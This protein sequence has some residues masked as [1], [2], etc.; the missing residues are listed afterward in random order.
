MATKRYPS[1]I[2]ATCVLPW[3]SD[4]VVDEGLFRAEIT[5]LREKLTRRLYLFGTAGEGYA[6]SDPQ[7]KQLV[8][9]FYSEMSGPDD[10]PMVG[11]ISL[12]LAT[13]VERIE[14][15]ASLGIKD[16]QIS[17]L[18]WGALTDREVDV[19]FDEVCSR[20]PS[21]RFLHYNLI[22]AQRMLIGADYARLS[23]A[24]SNLVAVKMGGG[25]PTVLLDILKRAP[26]LQCYFTEFGYASIRDAFEC[27]LLLSVS[28]VNFERAKLFF[29]SRGEQLAVL[30]EE[31]ELV[32]KPL[33][34]AVDN[35]GHM[36][37]AYDKLLLKTH[38]PDFPLRLLPPYNSAE[39][40]CFSKFLSELPVAWKPT[41]PCYGSANCSATTPIPGCNHRPL[42]I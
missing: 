14:Y 5:L 30:S 36:D 7:F 18:S 24:P 17:L 40:H 29:A 20:F 27:G 4:Y 21:C 19:F 15:C 3:R 22:R 42:A 31:L 32:M 8:R 38:L 2:L 25:D 13:I 33:I 6:V 1:A 35:L 37:G 16:F 11:V 26:A 28:M 39:E 41:P 12:S 10:H 9:V 34:R 23:A